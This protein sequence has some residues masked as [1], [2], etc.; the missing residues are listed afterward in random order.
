MAIMAMSWPFHG[1]FIDAR[2]AAGHVGPG[3][4]GLP[5]CHDGL[6]RRVVEVGAADDQDET[7]GCRKKLAPGDLVIDDLS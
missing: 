2:P 6:W 5:G 3:L 7:C 4:P 1:H